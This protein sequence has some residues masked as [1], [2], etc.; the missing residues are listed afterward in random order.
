MDQKSNEIKKPADDIGDSKLPQEIQDRLNE[1]IIR[2]CQ[3]QEV[4]LNE[5]MSQ[6]QEVPYDRIGRFMIETQ[7]LP[8]TNVV[9]V[10]AMMWGLAFIPLAVEFNF[11]AKA[12][13]CVGWSPRFRLANMNQPPP[14]YYVEFDGALVTVTEE[15]LGE[16]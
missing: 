6:E 7:F 15:K 10:P 11:Q 4:K 1:M 5:K 13:D 16:G 3:R 14:V 12:L 9:A 2:Q 8:P